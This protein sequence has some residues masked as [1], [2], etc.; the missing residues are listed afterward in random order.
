MMTLD[1]YVHKNKISVGLIK[2]D[3]E[4]MEQEFL[5]GAKQTIISQKPT[6]MISI[7]HSPQDFYQVK[8]L[9]E[10]WNL[11]YNFKIHRPVLKD[12]LGETLLICEQI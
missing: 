1:D 3:V 5:S 12:I 2:C 8:P 6:L 11:G 9:I 7:Y 4:G 10:S